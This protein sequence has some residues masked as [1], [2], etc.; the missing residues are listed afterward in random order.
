MI[1]RV[2]LTNGE[3]ALIWETLNKEAQKNQEQLGMA[4]DNFKK[5][6]LKTRNKTLLNIAA[7]FSPGFEEVTITK[8]G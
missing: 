4:G 5:E 6:I 3:K 2:Q 1:T 7:L 8:E